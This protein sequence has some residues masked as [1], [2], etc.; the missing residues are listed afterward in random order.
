MDQD[1]VEVHENAKNE[2]GGHPAIET[3]QAWLVKDLFGIKNKFFLQDT[4]LNPK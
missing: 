1:A 2:Q 3:E 4:A